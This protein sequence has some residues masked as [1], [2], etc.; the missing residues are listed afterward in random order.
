MSITPLFNRVLM[1]RE[2]LEKVGG[3][4]IPDDIKKKHATLKCKVVA[5]GEDVEAVK[6]GDVVLIGQYAGAWIN[7]DGKVGGEFEDE[8]YICEDGDVLA[9]LT[10]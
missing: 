1:E 7:I 9:I 6:P 8:L 3:I 5:V 4:I 2:K 10:E